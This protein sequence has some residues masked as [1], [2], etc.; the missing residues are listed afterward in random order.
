MSGDQKNPTQ[1]ATEQ[2]ISSTLKENRLFPPSAEFS[3]KA[4]I[5]SREEYE[6]LYR[7]SIDDP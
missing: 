6:R 3:A 1:A 5:K 7:E 4:R 2:A